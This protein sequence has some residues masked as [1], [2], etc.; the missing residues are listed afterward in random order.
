MTGK[1]RRLSYVPMLRPPHPRLRL[2]LDLGLVTVGGLR[3][4]SASLTRS[5]S[6][7]LASAKRRAC[8]QLLRFRGQTWHRRRHFCGR[9]GHQPGCCFP[10]S[11]HG[12]KPGRAPAFG[13][14]LALLDAGRPNVLGFPHL[15]AFHAEPDTMLPI[16]HYVSHRPTV[17]PQI[18]APAL[19]NPA[20]WGRGGAET[21]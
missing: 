14:A 16:G 6:L 15:L 12:A 5:S 1:G 19:L 13:V 7:A 3:G 17:P 4:S 21:W 8:L 18:P 11:Q 9:T 2:A 10:Q 20:R